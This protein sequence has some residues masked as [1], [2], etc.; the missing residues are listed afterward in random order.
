MELLPKEELVVTSGVDHADWNYDPLLSYL[1]RRR[2]ALVRGLLPRERVHRLLEIGFGSGIFMPELARRCDELHG[3]DVHAHVDEVRAAL[4]R[5]GIYAALSQQDA[6]QMTFPDG[7]FDLIVCVSSLEFIEDIAS[8]AREADRVLTRGGRIVGVVPAHSRF[9][10]SILH[11]LTG[12]NPQE[13]YGD[14][15]ERVIPALLQHFRIARKAR[16]GPVYTA[17]ALERAAVD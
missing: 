17:Y 13:D 1:M 9:F 8:A 10:D 5:H 16:F 15:R 12:A 7:Y 14:R 6:A 2:F 3:I 11:A 4:E